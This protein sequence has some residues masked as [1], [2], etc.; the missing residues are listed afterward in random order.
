MDKT[1]SF[2]DVLLKPQYSE[3]ESRQSVDTSSHMKKS[4]SLDLPVIAS[5]MDSVV[6][7]DMAL[8]L[9][10]YGGMAIVHRYNTVEDQARTIREV[11]ERGYPMN[12]G[13]AIGVTGDFL[14]R[15]SEARNSGANL[16]CVDIAHGHHTLMQNA[17]H[18]LRTKFGD[19]LHIMAGNVA[20]LEG[21]N[22]LADWGA[23]SVR[24]GIGGGSICSTRL[25]TGHGIPTFH[26]VMECAK[27]DRD[28]NLVA[29]GGLKTSGDIVKA[30]AA[31][32][33]AVMLGSMFAGTTES[34]GAI[35]VGKD[36]KEYKLYRGMASRSAQV[37]WRGRSS[38]PEGISTTIRYKGSVKNILADIDGGIRSGLSYSGVKNLTELRARAKFIQ[39]TSA[40][41]Q[42]SG[43]HILGR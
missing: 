41:L 17:L 30:L 43:T 35:A 7:S 4:I 24:V 26:S 9:D 3:I 12:I 14:E 38:S 1:L 2:D 34:P 31:G 19:S 37:D 40:G 36:G 27:S 16:L 33:D 23:D 11:T 32:A 18:A 10:D 28:A 6:G 21:F 22:A 25:Q 5:P 20:T 15:A 42:E 39:Q 13:A 29:D 8:A